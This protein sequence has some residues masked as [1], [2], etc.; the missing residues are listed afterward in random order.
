[1]ASQIIL[2]DWLTENRTDHRV[3][4]TTQGR[5]GKPLDLV[6][7]QESRSRWISHGSSRNIQ[8]KLQLDQLETKLNEKQST[9]L[10]LVRT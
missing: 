2:L 4:L 6:I 9:A 8:R 5:N 7:E 3:T 10:G 1:M